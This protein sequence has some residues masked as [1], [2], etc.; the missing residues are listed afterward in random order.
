MAQHGEPLG[1]ALAVGCVLVACQENDAAGDDLVQCL[2]RRAG[3]LARLADEAAHEIR[4]MRRA[5]APAE[6]GDV[7]RHRL[8][9]QIDR[10]LDR[11]G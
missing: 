11:L 4:L 10:L 7:H 9:I 1:I 5:T 6:R 3:R 2:G 8:A